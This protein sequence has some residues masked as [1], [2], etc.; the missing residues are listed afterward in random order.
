MSKLNVDT[1]EPEG[2]STTLTLGAS[3][4]TV[5]LGSGASA[6]GFDSGL[7]SVQTFT[8]SGTWT[9]PAGITKVIMEVQGAGGSGSSSAAPNDL[10]QGPGAGGGYA[11]KF[12]DVSSISTSTITV[13]AGG[14]AV[15]AAVGVA[16]GLSSWADGTNTIAGNGGNGGTLAN[17]NCVVGGTATG[18]DV[19]IQ[20]STGLW[21][22]Y[23]KSSGGHSIL[24]SG[25][26]GGY[27]TIADSDPTGYGGG[28]GGCYVIATAAGTGGIVIVWEYK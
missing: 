26:C 5:T 9:R 23:M 7:A 4:D 17:Y 27:N 12:L 15:T 13:G 8:S 1:I 21:F 18:G 16:G 20:G 14:G 10:Q 11:K 6:S 2:V 28:S 19:N 25:G 24:G 3:G 22:N